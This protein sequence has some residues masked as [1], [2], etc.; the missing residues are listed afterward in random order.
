MIIFQDLSQH[1]R[2][3]VLADHV[4]H[5][6]RRR[7]LF[8]ALVKNEVPFLRASWCIKVMYLNQVKIMIHIFDRG[9]VDCYF[10]TGL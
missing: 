2:L 10:Y 7:A 5:G 1:K 3:R 9:N 6:L 8:D 4:P